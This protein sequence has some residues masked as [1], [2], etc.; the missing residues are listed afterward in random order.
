MKALLAQVLPLIGLL[1]GLA[2]FLRWRATGR[3]VPILPVL[4]AC[5]LMGVGLFA[6]SDPPG[7]F[8][9]FRDAYFGA[10]VAL[11]QG[12]AALGP[13]I[14]KGTDG[15]VNLPIIAYAFWPLGALSLHAAMVI[16]SLAGVVCVL[17]AWLALVRGLSLDRTSSL[18]LLFVFACWGPLA[19]SV[20]EANLTHFLLWPLAASM[21]MLRR[22]E[23]FRAGVLLGL[24]ALVKLPL[25][26]FGVY[27]L[28]FG[29]WRVALGGALTCVAAVLASLAVFGWDMHV[30]WYEACIQPYANDPMPAFNVQS[31]QAYISRLQLGASGL[32]QWKVV[33][34]HGWAP[35]LSKLL[36]ALTYAGVLVFLWHARRL[37]GATAAGAPGQN[38]MLASDA[39]FMLVMALAC[40]TSPLSWSHYYCWFL[41]PAA[42]FL[43]SLQQPAAP[44]RPW[45]GLGWLALVACA[46]PVVTLRIDP[47]WL[48]EIHARST[49]S[50]LLFA[51][52][53]WMLWLGLSLRAMQKHSPS[54]RSSAERNGPQTGYFSPEG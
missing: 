48:A 35:M 9:D 28:F 22:G 51:G 8:E 3:T 46:A 5:A 47:W 12:P 4:G 2:V 42:F 13:M 31:V 37:S 26:L 21:L 1:I 11:Q 49:T 17:A 41:L 18:A 44:S 25:L 30:R 36:V 19:Y 6:V 50:V 20:R 38:G 15:F 33:P 29:R 27:Y 16:F 54:Q 7:L 40:V 45:R 53:L 34:L 10:G 24:A 14:D 39:E 32:F 43:R 23:D 52:L